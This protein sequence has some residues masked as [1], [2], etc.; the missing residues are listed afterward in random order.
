VARAI[1]TR[2]GEETVKRKEGLK[3][4]KKTRAKV[5]RKGS[6]MTLTVHYTSW[7]CPVH[8]QLALNFGGFLG[9]PTRS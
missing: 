3:P 1:I 5:L 2:D 8:R 4:I 7:G 6:K 9:M